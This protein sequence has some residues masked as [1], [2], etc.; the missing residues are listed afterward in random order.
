MTAQKFAFVVKKIFFFFDEDIIA[1][2]VDIFTAG[3]VPQRN[4]EYQSGKYIEE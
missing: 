1:E 4:R 2:G 3:P